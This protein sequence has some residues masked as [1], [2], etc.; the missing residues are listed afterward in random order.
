MPGPTLVDWRGQP[1]STADLQAPPLLRR[2]SRARPI[3]N[4]DPENLAGVFKKADDGDPRELQQMLADIESRDGH[5]GGVLETRRRALTRLKWYAAPRS[6]DKRDVDIAAS[7][8]QRLLDAAWY[9]PLTRS[10]LDAIHKM[11]SVCSLGWSALDLWVP[12]TVRWVDQQMTG[13]SPADDQ[14]V[15]WRDPADETKLVPIAPYTAI[16]HVASDPSGPLFRRGIGRALAVLYALKRLGLTTWASFVEMFGVARPVVGMPPGHKVSDLDE[17]EARIQEWM[18]AGYFIKPHGMSLEFPEPANTKSTGDPVHALLARYCDEQASKRIIGQ[19]MT[20]DNGSSRAQAEVHERVAEWIIEADA[21]DLAETITRDL[22]EPFVRLNYGADALVPTVGALIE[23]GE[24]REFQLRALEKLLPHGLKV[25]QKVARELAGFPTPDEGEELLGAGD[26]NDGEAAPAASRRDGA[27]RSPRAPR[28]PH[29]LTPAA[30][31][32]TKQA[33][34]AQGD[35]EDLV[36]RDAGAAADENWRA[37][38]QPFVA[39]AEDAA[40]QADSYADFLRRLAGKEVDGDKFVRHL[41]AANMGLRGV[42]DGTDE[43]D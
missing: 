37:D 31:P 34:L 11:W 38:L 29:D 20:S 16:V 19:T 28:R 3:F 2:S 39:A 26:G 22:V 8:Q 21:A 27:G 24:R 43:V 4:P 17:L 6:K 1:V 12:T 35:G 5:F 41:A 25:G 14:R 42:G 33:A 36:D 18:H 23:S 32:N 9:R 13:V 40:E 30:Y 15:E 7:V 10:L